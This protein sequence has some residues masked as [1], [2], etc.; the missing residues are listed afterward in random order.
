[1]A[2]PKE[3]SHKTAEVIILKAK[4]HFLQKGFAGTSINDIAN[5]AKINKSLIYHHFGS[6]EL[7]WKAVKENILKQVAGENIEAIDFQHKTLRGFLE[8]FIPFRFH[9]YAN[10]PD[11][12]RLMCWQ[13]LEPQIETLSGL[14]KTNFIHLEEEIKCLQK[15]GEIRVD[16]NPEMVNYMVMSMAANGFMDKAGF[17]SS[18]EGQEQY[19]KLIIESLYTILTAKQ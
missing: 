9:A 2:R 13:R 4:E 12:V 8:G 16:L 11:L 17:L 6:K 10:Q 1:M 3:E 19:L 18:H 14:A 5:D 15:A 7:L